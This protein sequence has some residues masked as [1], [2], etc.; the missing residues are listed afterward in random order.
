VNFLQNRKLLLRLDWTMVITIVG[1]MIL[2]VLFVYSAGF[3]PTFGEHENLYKRQL[4]WVV[5]GI[6]SFLVGAM[7]DY[8]N[9][10]EMAPL[11]YAVSIALLVIVMLV[12]VKM[13]GATRWLNVFGIKM[14]PSEVA[15]IG[16]VI[17]LAAMLSQ[18]GKGMK[19]GAPVVW[20][21]G[22]VALPFALIAMQPDLGTAAV[23]IPIALAMLIPAGL[24]F[25]LI[26][27]MVTCTIFVVFPLAYKFLLRDYHVERILEFFSHTND[28]Q[29]ASWNTIQSL[30]AVGSGGMSGKGFLQGVQSKLDYLP[31]D[32]APND[33][34]FSVIA[35]EKGFIGSS[36]VIGLYVALLL[37]VTRAAIRAPDRFGRMLA[38]GILGMLFSHIFVNI[39]MTIGVM[40]I[41]GLPLPLLSYGGSFM[42]CTMVALGLTQSIYIRR[43]ER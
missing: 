17:M 11:I 27:V 29:G 32:V 42:V 26:S 22:V 25:R 15:K 36:I 40:P 31:R 23:L 18:S 33:F 4:L 43:Y 12:G 34:I 13:N 35:E 38:L 10:K 7:Y 37:G 14:Q 8:R 5:V 1:L 6:V 9:L 16:A 41:I 20:I 39:A 3:R 24:S 28:A 2:G 30:L 19:E 21:L